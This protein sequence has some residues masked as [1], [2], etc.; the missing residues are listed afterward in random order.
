MKWVD[1]IMWLPRLEE[2]FLWGLKGVWYEIFDFSFFHVSVY[3]GPSVSQFGHFKVY[4]TDI[5]KYCKG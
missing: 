5:W 2:L 1:V 4:E 3:L